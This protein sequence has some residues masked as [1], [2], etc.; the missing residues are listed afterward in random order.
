MM[1]QNEL[2]IL[3]VLVIFVGMC[4]RK[5]RASVTPIKFSAYT[6]DWFSED[7]IG[8]FNPPSSTSPNHS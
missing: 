1:K 3:I 6:R 2:L 8:R 5:S 7:K 4:M